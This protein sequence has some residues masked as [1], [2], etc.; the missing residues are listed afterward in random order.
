MIEDCD[1]VFTDEA[2]FYFGQLV[3]DRYHEIKTKGYVDFDFDKMEETKQEVLEDAL[4]RAC[5]A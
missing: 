3:A 5:G 4:R 1:G 2:A